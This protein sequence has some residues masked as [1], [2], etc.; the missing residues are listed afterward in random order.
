MK[1]KTVESPLKRAGLT[2]LAFIIIF[3]VYAFAVQVTEINLDKMR[4]ENKQTQL[5]GVLRFLADPDITNPD[6]LDPLFVADSEP[7]S[8]TEITINTLNLIVETIFMAL[9]ATTIGT[10]LAIPLSFL[11]ARNLMM[12][13]TAPLASFM[14]ALALLPVGGGL[15]L[16]GARWMSNLAANFG[17]Q[18]GLGILVLVVAVAAA[19]LLL[20]F[21]PPLLSE[22]KR[23]RGEITL[24]VGQMALVILLGL[25]SLAVLATLG[26]RFGEWLTQV[27]D[28]AA[29]PLGIFTLNLSFLGNF[30]VVTS[31]LISL[32]LPAITSLL[33]AFVAV[34][35]G[36]SYG[37]ETILRIEGTPARILT[38]VLTFL[39]S[40][41]LIYGIGA[42]LNWLYQFDNPTN[43]TIW[44]A[45]VLGGLAA[46]GSLFLAPKR[47][48]AIGAAIYTISRGIFNILRSIE[49]LIM[50]I[51]FVVWMGLGPFAGVMALT[52]HTI[53]ALGKLFS[54]QIEGIS[55][56]PIEAIT[57]TGANRLQTVVFGVI[58]QI[59]PPYIA[60]TLYRWDI[61]VRMSTII[62]FV[63][64]GGIGFL[65]SQSIRLLR[66]RDASVMMLAIAIVVS[67]LDYVSARVRTRII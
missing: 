9:L 49:P 26:E 10:I 22:K 40:F 59:I 6:L 15:G 57:S 23:S 8:L 51:V 58:P 17:Q 7:Y 4:S 42:A 60:Y 14:L 62:G 35:F 32:M 52:L 2:F 28:A 5:I 66:Y 12:E 61:N 63:G 16:L 27:L 47:P 18:T 45:L 46:V 19:W 50:A 11:A 67:A 41:V 37:Q 44:P 34:T 43:W 38:A 39:G 48:F 29:V 55:E 53:A 56:G 1:E 25:F 30:V 64:G 31:D 54:E 13:V 3:L 36:S 24:A 65:L 21:G 20:R 33:A